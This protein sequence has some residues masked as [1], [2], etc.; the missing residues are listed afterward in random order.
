MSRHFK[1]QFTVSTTYGLT[2]FDL[3]QMYR[4][5]SLNALSL[6]TIS[7]CSLASTIVNGVFQH[8]SNQR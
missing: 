7:S 4:L 3:F 5:S 8:E 6:Y 1:D 2:Q